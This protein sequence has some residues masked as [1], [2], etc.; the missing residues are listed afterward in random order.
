MT[1]QQDDDRSHAGSSGFLDIG[2]D[3]NSVLE[4]HEKK[5]QDKE[6]EALAKGMANAA[7]GYLRILVYLV[8]LIVAVVM[9]VVVYTRMTSEE[10][11][12]FE[13]NFAAYADKLT[14]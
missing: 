12:T 4:G 2:D 7:V 6:R 13:V 9:C 8:V 11:Q 10:Q 1:P 14:E 3:E 5:Q